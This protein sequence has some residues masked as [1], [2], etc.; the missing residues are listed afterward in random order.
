MRLSFFI[1]RN[2]QRIDHIIFLA[3]QGSEDRWIVK[4]IDDEMRRAWVRFYGKLNR[5]ATQKGVDAFDI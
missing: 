1:N 5:W 4:V 3:A 2:R